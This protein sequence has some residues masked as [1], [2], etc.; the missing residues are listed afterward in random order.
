[1]SHDS[2][3]DRMKYYE[4][5]E[6][7]RYFLPGLP[8]VARMDGRSFHSF[9]KGLERPFDAIYSDCMIDATR[10]LVKETGAVIGYTQSDEITLIWGPKNFQQN[11]WFD[12]KIFKMTSQ[13]AAL[14]TLYFYQEVAR[15]LP[16]L[17]YK[18]PSFDARVFQVPT[19]E[20]AVNC[21]LWRE[22]DAT[23][24]SISMAVSSVYSEREL[25]GKTSSERQELLF[26]KGINW[27]DYP[28][29]FKRGTYVKRIE[30]SRPY[31]A[32][33]ISQLPEKHHA[34]TNP[35]LVVTRSGVEPFNP[36]PL[37]KIVNKEGFVFC[38]EKPRIRVTSM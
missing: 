28:A 15:N 2:L 34:R 29:H 16:G 36:P 32:H 9:T 35:Q 24:N 25:E 6:T 1:M 22:W 7:G 18:D 11:S 20:E 8:I 21:L 33:E 27:N 30:V 4:S 10:K 23:K 14:T 12:R 13:L 5:Y 38:N 37:N 3:G 19:K 31:S 26:Q 17:A